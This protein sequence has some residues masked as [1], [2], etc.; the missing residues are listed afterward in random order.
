MRRYLKSESKLSPQNSLLLERVLQVPD[1]W[2]E[3]VSDKLENTY[4]S[5]IIVN[6]FYQV[7]DMVVPRYGGK[8]KYSLEY[9]LPI[10]D[11][12]LRK[13]Y[14]SITGNTLL[15]GAL[16]FAFD[17]MRFIE[18]NKEQFFESLRSR[19]NVAIQKSESNRYLV[20]EL[21]FSPKDLDSR[22]HSTDPNFE[23]PKL[24]VGVWWDDS[25]TFFY[26]ET[27]MEHGQ[28]DVGVFLSIE[29]LIATPGSQSNTHVATDFREILFQ[30]KEEQKPA[31]RHE[32]V[33]Y[34]Q[35]EVV[36]SLSPYRAKKIYSDYVNDK[37]S[38]QSR[39]DYLISPVEIPAWQVNTAY[40]FMLEF[41]KPNSIDTD[42]E[43]KRNFLR[44]IRTNEFLMNLKS[45]DEKLYRRALTN[46]WSAIRGH[47]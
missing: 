7:A 38:S 19:V 6:F 10:L 33:H 42:Q 34:I 31:I 15:S 9:L 13:L 5:I 21:E 4:K 12:S 37:Q 8:L 22:Y 3:E 39:S 1:G 44:W 20:G 28:T 43:Y 18:K 25:A 46:I 41:G 2:V 29:R 17:K 16:D 40:D 11:G 32:L 35:K 36:S 24:L 14:N 47:K 45:R 27:T 26:G 23:L 30:T